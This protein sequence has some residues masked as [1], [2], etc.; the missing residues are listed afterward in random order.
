[1][2]KHLGILPRHIPLKLSKLLG[3]GSVLEGP[4]ELIAY[5]CDGQTLNRALPGLAVLPEST[6]QVQAVVRLLADENIPFVSRGAGTGLAGGA[7]AS[8]NEVLILMTRMNKILNIDADNRV[9]RVQAGVPNLEIS[10]AVHEFGLHYAPDPSSQQTSTLGG[11]VATNAGG[12]HT[13]KY[14]VTT[15]HIRGLT[16]VMPD[17]EISHLGTWA[18][19]SPGLDLRGLVVGSE[20]T[21][22][23]VTEAVI[24]LVPLPKEY[25]TFLSAF[26]SPDQAIRVVSKIIASGLMPAALEMMDQKII[27]ALNKAFGMDFPEDAGA[28]LLVE[29]DGDPESVS[30]DAKAVQ[31]IFEELGARSI[32]IAKNESERQNLWKARKR[33]FGAIGRLAP[34]YMT[35][36]AV[37]PRSRLPEVLPKVYKVAQEHQLGVANIFHAG[38]GNLHPCLLFDE[39]DPVQVENVWKA[40]GEIQKI[41]VEAGGTITGEHGIGTQKIPYLS[42]VF[43]DDDLS[44]MQD[45]RCV[46]NPKSL[47]NPGKVLPMNH[48]CAAEARAYHPK[49]MARTP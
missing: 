18:E 20:G 3:K 9:A 14:G 47:L 19:D 29:L 8:S 36:D 41:C 1:M 7:L 37:I 21:L 23:I 42:L 2:K 4:S 6:E 27:S 35:Q 26:D 15:N 34:S 33:A 49:N 28:I 16:M 39:R 22:G 10:K 44:L 25:R 46:F 30:G 31:A 12:P 24:R 43:S 38:D 32:R 11:N 17:G 48:G 13:L 45:I 5:E 40:S